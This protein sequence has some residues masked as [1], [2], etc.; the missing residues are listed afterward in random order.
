MRIVVQGRDG[1]VKIRTFVFKREVHSLPAK[2]GVGL[3]VCAYWVLIW[4]ALVLLMTILF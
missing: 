1:K 3:V 4:T 2:I